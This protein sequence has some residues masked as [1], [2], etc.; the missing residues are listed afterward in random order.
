MDLSCR[1]QQPSGEY[2]SDDSSDDV[3][4]IDDRP[5]SALNLTHIS[6]RGSFEDEGENLVNEAREREKAFYDS[7]QSNELYLTDDS[8]GLELPTP[9]PLYSG[10]NSSTRS[11]KVS[12]DGGPP[13]VYKVKFHAEQVSFNSFRLILPQVLVF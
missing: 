8:T 13:M 11:V 9:L 5:P 6:E 7:V 12:S 10:G 3:L 4:T 1:Q 2:D